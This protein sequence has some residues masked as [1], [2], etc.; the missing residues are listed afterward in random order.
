[1]IL[2]CFHCGRTVSNELPDDTVIRGTIECPECSSNLGDAAARMRHVIQEV[3]DLC[4][5]LDADQVRHVAK[6]WDKAC[7]DAH[8]C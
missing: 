7:R 4:S 5:T 1:M 8:L 3:L 2:H 6:D